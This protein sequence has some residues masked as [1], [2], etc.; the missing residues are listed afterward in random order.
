[1]FF[2]NETIYGCQSQCF[3]VYT[4][5]FNDML[6]IRCCVVI[7][8]ALHL[9]CYLWPSAYH[10]AATFYFLSC[11]TLA[12]LSLIL[13]SCFLACCFYTIYF[14]FVCDILMAWPLISW[15]TSTS[16][17]MVWLAPFSSVFHVN[18]KLTGS[19]SKMVLKLSHACSYLWVIFL[20]D[21]RFG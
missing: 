12:E 13:S 3:I 21:F 19:F 15:G 1:M 9:I 18:V 4:L 5:P 16:D 20:Y 14:T 8:F 2:S 7:V 11:L 17:N 6:S 10:I